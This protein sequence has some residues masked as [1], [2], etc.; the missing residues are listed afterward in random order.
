MNRKQFF[1]GVGAA[2]VALPLARLASLLPELPFG[3][4]LLFACRR[5][6][7]MMLDNFGI[8]MTTVSLSKAYQDFA[9]AVGKSVA[10]LDD[11]ERQ[12]AVLAGVMGQ[13]EGLTN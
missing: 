6:S 2:L 3:D 1:K 8:S 7:L 11:N 9:A 5:G 10:E 13:L 4:E 12:I